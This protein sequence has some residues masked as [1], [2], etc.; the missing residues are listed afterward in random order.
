MGVPTNSEGNGHVSG[1]HTD[2]ENEDIDEADQALLDADNEVVETEE[3]VE[4][5]ALER[6]LGEPAVP[7]ETPPSADEE[8]PEQRRLA[9]ARRREA[10]T[11]YTA[12]NLGREVSDPNHLGTYQVEAR[13][14]VEN[15]KHDWCEMVAERVSQASSLAHPLPDRCPFNTQSWVR[16][17]QLGVDGTWQIV[18]RATSVAVKEVLGRRKFGR[19]EALALP[20]LREVDQFKP[21]VYVDHV[22]DDGLEDECIDGAYVGSAT[23]EN[24]LAGR[25]V[26]YDKL[27]AGGLPNDRE[28]NGRHLSSGLK[29]S[30]TMH[31]RPLMIFEDGFDRSIALLIEGLVMDFL[32]TVDR[33]STRTI[34]TGNGRVLQ[35]PEILEA[36]KKAFPSQRQPP[37]FKGLN[38]VSALKQ[39]GPARLPAGACPMGTPYCVQKP[40]LIVAAGVSKIVCKLCYTLW[41]KWL[42]DGKAVSD[43]VD[44]WDKFVAKRK[45]VKP[46]FVQDDSV[47]HKVHDF[48]CGDCKIDHKTERRLQN[49]R[50]RACKECKHVFARI[51]QVA[52]HQAKCEGVYNAVGRKPKRTHKNTCPKC[53]ETFTEASSLFRHDVEQHQGNKVQKS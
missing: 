41:R 35:C 40:Q 1:D 9:T 51:D 43:A 6:L 42:R 29:P 50:C 14:H 37:A 52:P 32:G 17:R 15:F 13:L 4:E 11:K 7:E 39:M 27:K 10:I 8:T 18:D 36:G 33:T 16:L 34:E 19:L 30:A 21:G 46:A 5:A 28:R 2:N 24:G 44:S 45:A 12:V 31:L 48:V 49:H 53:G 20:R 25:W 47:V 3:Q 22:Q 26:K 23:G 38:A